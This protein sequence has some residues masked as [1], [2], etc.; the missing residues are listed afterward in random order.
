M[1]TS[2]VALFAIIASAA[3]V[4][5][6]TSSRSQNCTDSCSALSDSINACFTKLNTTLSMTVSVNP[7]DWSTFDTSTSGDWEGAKNCICNDNA[8]NAASS[9]L[10]CVSNNS[11]PLSKD[12]LTVDDYK[13]MC[14]DPNTGFYKLA[15]RY[16]LM[17][18]A[19]EKC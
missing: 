19:D 15:Q 16:H 6:D 3:A 8:Y 1:K 7:A 4:P 2:L 13:Q 10:T 17:R 12:P 9:C 5:Q 11:C 18:R 14:K